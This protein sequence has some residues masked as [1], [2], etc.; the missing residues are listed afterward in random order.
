MQY[1]HLFNLVP[2]F[3]LERMAKRNSNLVNKFQSKVESYLARLNDDQKNKLDILMV[4]EIDDLQGLM[5]EAYE[6]T[7]KK[8]FKILADPSYKEFIELNIDEVRKLV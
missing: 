7:D 6:K 4:S 8:Q 2:S 3:L 1:E 5:A